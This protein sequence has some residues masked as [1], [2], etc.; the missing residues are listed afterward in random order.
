MKLVTHSLKFPRPVLSPLALLSV[1]LPL[2]LQSHPA[3]A[4]DFTSDRIPQTSSTVGLR[5]EQST[6]LNQA[7]L[8]Q[9]WVN[10]E[11]IYRQTGVE[12]R[13]EYCPRNR[14]HKNYRRDR[15]DRDRH[16]RDRRYKSDNYYYDH[17]DD[18][19]WNDPFWSG[20]SN[21][22]SYG[23]PVLVSSQNVAPYRQNTPRLR[24]FFI[25]P[26]TPPASGLR[27]VIRNQTIGSSPAP[28]TDREYDAGSRSES[29]NLSPGDDHHSKHLAVLKGQN[30]MTYQIKRGNV[31]L[32]SGEFTV[33]VDI[34]DRYT[35]ISKTLPRRVVNVPCRSRYRH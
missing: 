8:Y 28:Y 25:S 12:Y 30:L 24:A 11:T 6:Q 26:S 17:H 19:A 22:S 4:T 9:S 16:D 32:E 1:L 7:T 10:H 31:V 29:F 14:D 34:V 5:V 13:R 2:T 35:S 15:H 3:I 20:Y 21:E 33:N 23:P 18:S 27:V